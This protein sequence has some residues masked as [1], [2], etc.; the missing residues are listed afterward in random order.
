[1]PH[2]HCPVVAVTL[3]ESFDQRRRR[4]AIAL[5][6]RAVVLTRTR[7][8]RHAVTGYR[9]AF[10]I[11][12][13][14]PGWRRRGRGRKVGEDPVLREQVQHTVEP[15]ELVPAGLRL[16]PRPREDPYGYEVN[17]GLAHQLNV[18]E[19]DLLRPLLGVVV[20]SVEDAG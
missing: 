3:C 2:R 16:E 17:A 6:R 15:A 14:K 11:T 5:T 13:R 4:R 1:M 10:G 8:E 12:P 19:P 20:A 9:Q 18:L 7:P